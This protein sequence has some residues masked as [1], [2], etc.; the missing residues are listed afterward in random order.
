M[1]MIK[2]RILETIVQD[3]H[4]PVVA[5]LNYVGKASQLII[6]YCSN[7]NEEVD[8]EIIFDSPRGFKLLDEGD[9]HDYWESEIIRNNWLFEIESGGWLDRADA[10]GGFISKALG[11][12]EFLISGID[13]CVS[14]IS[15][16]DPV[17]SKTAL[18]S[19]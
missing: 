10:S 2:A 12:R 3:F 18:S 8:Y 17:I 13:D 7:G 19:L 1:A 4:S 6:Y 14:V 5:G 16:T 11:F 9:M 15:N